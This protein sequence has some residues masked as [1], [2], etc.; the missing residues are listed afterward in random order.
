MQ[1]TGPDMRSKPPVPICKKF[2]TCRRIYTHSEFN[3][4]CF[5]GLRS[6]YQSHRFPFAITTAL[7][8]QLVSAHGQYEIEIQLQT[9]EGEIVWKDGPPGSCS[10]DE[11]LM[12]YEFK[13]SVNLVFPKPGPYVVVLVVNGEE[14][15]REPSSATLSRLPAQAD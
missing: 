9:P 7:F 13:L 8:F 15:E 3:D 2:L 6:H 14:L 1:L 5:E 10:L 4:T 12:V 11:T